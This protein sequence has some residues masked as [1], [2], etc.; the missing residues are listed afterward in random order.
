LYR[1]Q[2]WT[3]IGRHSQLCEQHAEERYERGNQ[4]QLSG[5]VHSVDTVVSPDA[6]KGLISLS[7]PSLI[8]PQTRMVRG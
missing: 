5:S 3:R 6:S 7:N 8:A 2:V 1:L 4:A